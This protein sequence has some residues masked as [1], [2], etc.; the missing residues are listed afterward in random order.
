MMHHP[1][2]VQTVSF[3]EHEQDCASCLHPGVSR[4]L[5]YG[6]TCTPLHAVVVAGWLVLDL[7]SDCGC[8][9]SQKTDPSRSHFDTA[10]PEHWKPLLAGIMGI[11]TMTRGG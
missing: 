9:S 3:F 7:N 4:L 6:H 8:G 2:H 1:A 5:R 10:L 11:C